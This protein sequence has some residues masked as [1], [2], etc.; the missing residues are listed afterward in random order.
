M[1]AEIALVALLAILSVAALWTPA[2][3]QGFTIDES[4]WISTSRYFWITF[5]ERDIFG[6]AWQ[7][8]YLVLTHPP[9]ARYFIGLGLW[10]QGW[11]PD[12]LN[13]RYDST[14]SR[15]FNRQAGNIPSAALLRDARDVTFL[16]AVG[17]VLLLYPAG[18]ILAGPLGGV[19]AVG[20]AVV[21]P[22]LSTLWTRALAEATLAF[23]S[24]LALCLAL[25]YVPRI[26][27]PDA[28]VAGPIGVG[29]A[30]GL[31]TATKL[32][33]VL[34]AIG[35][36]LF[37]VLQQST[38]LRT[39]RRP[40][41]LSH[42]L[43]IGIF[44]AI[45]FILANPLLY[46]DPLGRTVMLFRHRQEEMRQQMISTPYLAAPEEIGPRAGLVARRA[47]EE[48]GTIQRWARLPLDAAVVAVGLGVTIAATW[49]GIRR[50][51]L[52]GPRALLLCWTVATYSL[53][54]WNFGYNSSHYFAPLV[55]LNVVLQALALAVA[56]HW[57]LSARGRAPELVSRFRLHASRGS[58]GSET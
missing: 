33:G 46:P 58:G 12:E 24:L 37:A 56:V 9:L 29:V 3:R 5:L 53:S 13:G 52:P 17:A 25:V 39:Q 43:D 40:A 38:L 19:A 7:P 23:F 30:L 28:R 57:A 14:R 20:L 51:E 26:P 6:P 22:L 36:A 42:W 8:N 45:V 44:A 49:Q 54:T 10:L 15:E 47:F 41:G 1:V 21:N 11:T 2:T 4:R 16:F 32:S 27:R 31:A 50:R 48:Y 35:L 55:T 18:R 34:G